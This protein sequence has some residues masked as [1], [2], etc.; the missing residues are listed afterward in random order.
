MFKSQQLFDRQATDWGFRKTVFSQVYRSVGNNNR[1]FRISS[2][3][4]AWRANLVGMHSTDAGG[5]YRESVERMCFEL[6]APVL[7]LFTI[8]PN[9][10]ADVGENR[11]TFVP[12]PMPSKEKVD[13][14]SLRV[15]A[16]E[17]VGKLMGLSLRSKHLLPLQLAPIVWKGL[18]QERI[19]LEDILAIDIYSYKLIRKIQRTLGE[20]VADD[21][22]EDEKSAS[23]R[24]DQFN[25]EMGDMKFEVMNSARELVPLLPG[26]SHI[27]LNWNNRQQFLQ[28][29]IDFRVHEFDEQFKAIR[30]GLAQIVPIRLLSL[31]S[32]S[33]LSRLV[34]GEDQMNIDLMQSVAQYESYNANHPVVQMFWT[35][36]RERFTEEERRKFLQFTWGRSRLPLSRDTFGSRYFKIQRYGVSNPDKKLP[37]SHTCFFSIEIPEYSNID[38]MTDRIRYAIHNCTGIDGDGSLQSDGSSLFD[39]D[40]DGMPQ[41]LF[42]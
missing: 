17:F 27:T 38:I 15:S 20:S 26:G 19:T 5:P 33:D 35:M 11:D 25:Q 24:E 12:R 23:L 40:E 29:L 36:F 28:A 1:V 18:V 3:Y 22:D 32:W 41:S 8:C 16:F 2:D 9:G 4:R 6:Q 21:E 30:R 14:Y 13:E 37:I 10:A 7:P 31:F 34:C 42:T 39:N